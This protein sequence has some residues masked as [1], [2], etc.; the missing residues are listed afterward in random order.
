MLRKICP[1]G[2]SQGIS[3]PKNI[4][5]KLNLEIGSQVEVELDKK[6]TKLTIKATSEKTGIEAIDMKFASQVNDFIKK[7]RPALKALAKK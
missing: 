7:Y 1:I 5:E 2:N 6:R 4:L 3:I